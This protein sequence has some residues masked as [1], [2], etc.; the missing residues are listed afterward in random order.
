MTLP[1]CA[2]LL[3]PADTATLPLCPTAD[4]PVFIKI[5][6]ES[7]A[8]AAPVEMVIEPDVRD[9]DAPVL[10]SKSPVAVVES[11]VVATMLPEAPN[12]EVPERNKSAPPVCCWLFP[13]FISILPPF[14]DAE[15]PAWRT[16][17]P[18]ESKLGP[19]LS[20]IEPLEPAAEL[21]DCI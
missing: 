9:C 21:P 8:V 11:A 10:I 16:I 14:P 6:P 18:S 2:A 13:A 20:V 5:S 15:A 19:A 7:P 3:S 1:P 4:F 12:S 17:S